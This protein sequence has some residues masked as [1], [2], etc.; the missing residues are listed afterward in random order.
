MQD[1]R[2]KRDKSNIKGILRLKRFPKKV[3]QCGLVR[4]YS[5]FT[6]RWGLIKKDFKH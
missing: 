5:I 4:K 2:D 6:V 1:G 3:D